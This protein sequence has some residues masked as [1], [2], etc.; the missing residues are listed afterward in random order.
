[1]AGPRSRRRPLWLLLI[2]VV[3]TI[4]IL[5]GQS[6][7]SAHKS[8]QNEAIQ[9]YLDQLRPGIQTSTTDGSDFSDIRANASTLGLAG[10][11]RRLARLSNSVTTT[12]DD[13]D[14][15]T[16]PPSMRVAQAYLVA[17]LGVRAKAVTEASPALDAALT[18]TPQPDAG[19]LDAATQL[20]DVGQD[21]ELG[22]RSFALFV[23]A[24]PAGI[25]APPPST[26]V[27][28]PTQWSP[29]QLDAYVTTLRSSTSVTP[30]H[31][32]AMV[33][34]STDP[35]AVAQDNGAEVIPAA[36]NMTVSMVVENVG[37][38]TEHNLTITAVL[39]LAD[40]SQQMLRDFIDLAPG[41][42]RAITLDSMHPKAGTQGV[43]TLTVQPVAGEL[44]Q[45]NNSLSTPV[46]FK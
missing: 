29:V 36:Q 4:V 30:V 45:A 16:P 6:A 10:L 14:S 21:L 25:A 32:L 44:N 12:L 11:D 31:D 7:S 8:N 26:W 9:V 22:D 43:L 34:F 35:S 13:V 37:N 17:A 38:Q 24:L 18:E 46:E 2:A 19:L 39:S 15:L 40:G 27:T 1:M 23:A 42:T 41:Q 3:V 28:D 5:I 20:G 33:A